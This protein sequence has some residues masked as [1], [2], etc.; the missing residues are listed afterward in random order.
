MFQLSQQRLGCTP[1]DCYYDC[2]EYRDHC[3]NNCCPCL[4]YED[5]KNNY[6]I[7]GNCK[8]HE[9]RPQPQLINDEICG[10]ISSPCDGTETVLWVSHFPSSFGTL[11]VFNGRGCGKMTVIINGNVNFIVND[12]QTRSITSPDLHH[13]AIRCME[14]TGRC[15][16]SYC[17]ELHYERQ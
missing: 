2:Q 13:I 5:P 16:G 7:T 14:G 3:C 11:S 10:N 4:C 17:L 15:T 6:Y 8:E 12:G 9:E 1:N